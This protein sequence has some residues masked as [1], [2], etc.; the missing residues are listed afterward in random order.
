MLESFKKNKWT[1]ESITKPLRSA[2]S[3]KV[4]EIKEICNKM[5]IETIKTD[6]KRFAIDYAVKKV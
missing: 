1:V 3:Y 2:G 5:N 4:A 6:K